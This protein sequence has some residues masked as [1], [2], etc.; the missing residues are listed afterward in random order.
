[1][2]HICASRRDSLKQQQPTVANR[3][4]SNIL[5]ATCMETGWWRSQPRGDKRFPVTDCSHFARASF[6]WQLLRVSSVH[7][8]SL[9]LLCS[10]SIFS[11]LSFFSVI[12]CARFP[13]IRER[14]PASTVELLRF[15]TV[16][17][18]TFVIFTSAGRIFFLSFLLLALRF[19]R[20]PS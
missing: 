5:A 13:T 1:M 8:P 3:R 14:F 18:V 4:G 2:F 12:S 20:I 7:S 10:R 9:Q 17:F 16:L 19:R 11:W 15:V 6:T